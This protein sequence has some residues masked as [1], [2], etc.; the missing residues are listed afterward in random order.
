MVEVELEDRAV[1]AKNFHRGLV[2][3]FAV[4][5][6]AV[7]SGVNDL[8]D[9]AFE[10][11]RGSFE[12]PNFVAEVADGAFDAGLHFEYAVGFAHFTFWVYGFIDFRDFAFFVEAAWAD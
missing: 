2:A 4:A 11:G 9:Q 12:V 7:P 10:A 5:A 8:L 6:H 3:V 1:D